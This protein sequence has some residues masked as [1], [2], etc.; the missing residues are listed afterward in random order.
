ML[1][2][3][4]PILLLYRAGEAADA[5]SH[6]EFKHGVRPVPGPFSHALLFEHVQRVAVGTKSNGLDDPWR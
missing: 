4:I 6:K 3:S 2:L 5:P 1:K